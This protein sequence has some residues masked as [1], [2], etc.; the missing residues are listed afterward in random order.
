MAATRAI[1]LPKPEAAPRTTVGNTSLVNTVSTCQITDCT[2]CC[3]EAGTVSTAAL[4]AS[5]NNKVHALHMTN[6]ICKQV[7]RPS[8]SITRAE[9]APPSSSATVM[10]AIATYGTL[11]SSYFV[12]V[13]AGT[14][15]F[16]P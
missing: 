7:R 1:E 9:A 5:G 12:L 10:T 2:S 6:P 11:S 8:R 15:I 3:T 16:T 4:G 13:Y 14:H